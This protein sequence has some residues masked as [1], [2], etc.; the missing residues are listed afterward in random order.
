MRLTNGVM[1][2]VEAAEFPVYPG[3]RPVK[4]SGNDIALQREPVHPN[5]DP[6]FG[7][8]KR[9]PDPPPAD[10]TVYEYDTSAPAQ[11][12]PAGIEKVIPPSVE[13]NNL[14]YVPKG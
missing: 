14:P 2:P 1:D 5:M 9:M 4:Y 13:N 12:S 3:L 6:G 10:N 7:G 8:D 11:Y